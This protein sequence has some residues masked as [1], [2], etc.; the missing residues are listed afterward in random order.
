MEYHIKI[1]AVL[2]EQNSLF[3]GH[4]HKISVI[5]M[6]VSPTGEVTMALFSLY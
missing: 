3:L 5:K 4:W 6:E 2:K 1:N